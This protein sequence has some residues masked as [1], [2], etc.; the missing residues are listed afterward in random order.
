[1]GPEDAN[2][3]IVENYVANSVLIQ[4]HSP[5]E[6]PNSTVPSAPLPTGTHPCL[7]DFEG[8][9]GFTVSQEAL[10]A[11]GTSHSWSYSETL[12]QVFIKMN[13]VL[14]V[15]FKT[16]K[17]LGL[18]GEQFFIR[19]LLVYQNN[20]F[21]SQ[22]VNR[23]SI[24]WMD[25]DSLQLA[26]R[27]P[28]FCE[29]IKYNLAG[30]VLRCQTENAQYQFDPNSERHS[31]VVD[32]PRTPQTGSDFIKA[33]HYIFCC[34]TSCPKGM[35]RRAVQVV[36]TLEDER[37]QVHGRKVLPV[38]ICSCP[39]RDKDRQEKDLK[40]DDCADRKGT[41]RPM[42]SVVEDVKPTKIEREAALFNLQLRHA[43][44][45]S[46]E[47]ALKDLLVQQQKDFEQMK[48]IIS[49]MES[50]QNTMTEIVK[51]FAAIRQAHH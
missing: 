50:R 17:P 10:N 4:Q 22:A 44:R 43:T 45:E 1:M 47:T 20:D 19:A 41:K 33:V 23:C 40:V 5:S 30:H 35:Q 2:N 18:E 24:H 46:L 15:Q 21:V 51:Q 9:Y 25:D 8:E 7:E 36:F 3:M 6:L 34:K 13:N 12:K 28:K 29:C 38:K 48:V 26:H 27:S 32:V 49:S 37:C 42:T 31:V 11:T 16:D 39:K 14:M